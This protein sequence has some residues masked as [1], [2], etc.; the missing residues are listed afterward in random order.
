MT[1]NASDA[2]VGRAAALVPMLREQAAA[3]E[4]NRRLSPEVFDALS[5]ADIFRMTAPKRFGGLEADFITQCR[6]LAEIAR[7][8]GSASWVATIFSAMSW[9]VGTLSDQAQEE[10]FD[11]RDPRI[12][13]VFSPT[14]KAVRTSGGFIVS[15]RW[16]FNTGGH[17]SN[18]TVVNAVAPNA[19]GIELPTCM[20]VPAESCS[21]ST[22]GMRAAWPRR[23][24][25]RSS[26][27]TCSCR[28]TVPASCRR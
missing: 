5:A 20:L 27:R 15:G 12:S 16:G 3:N 17:G 4:T 11:T 19:A 10:I 21:A 2:L 28:S 25:A 18:W 13:G 24:A 26:R 14:G 23:A 22:I 7:G 1:S 8:C 9:L 6:V